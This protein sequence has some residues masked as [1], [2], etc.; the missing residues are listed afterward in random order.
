MATAYTLRL[1]QYNDEAVKLRLLNPDGLPVSMGTPAQLVFKRRPGAPESSA[2]VYTTT[3]GDD[4]W[5]EFNP[6][7]EDLRAWGTF[8][9]RA[10]SLPDGN[11]HTHIAGAL[12][13]A[14]Q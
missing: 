11:L 4:G 7:S 6:P 3:V 10:D 2:T 14:P 12:V 5:V 9:F 13:V 1:R 8:F